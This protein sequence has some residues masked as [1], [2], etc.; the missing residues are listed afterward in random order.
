M[1]LCLKNKIKKNL[2]IFKDFVF[3]CKGLLTFARRRP[4]CLKL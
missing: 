3:F 2:K 1:F 4:A